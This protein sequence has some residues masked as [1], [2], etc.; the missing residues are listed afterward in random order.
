VRPT[1]TKKYAREKVH[2]LSDWLSIARQVKRRKN[3]ISYQG[4]K[5]ANIWELAEHYEIPTS[6]ALARLELGW[7]IDR[8]VKQKW[9]G[10]DK[11]EG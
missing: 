5:F 4:R 8:L 10:H 6:V 1:L 11:E 3:K 2:V 7:E 9:E